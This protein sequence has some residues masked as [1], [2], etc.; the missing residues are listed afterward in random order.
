VRGGGSIIGIGQWFSSLMWVFGH[1]TVSCVAAK[2]PVSFGEWVPVGK[3]GKA[4]AGREVSGGRGTIS[5]VRV[6]WSYFHLLRKS[7]SCV[8]VLFSFSVMYWCINCLLVGIKPLFSTLTGHKLLSKLKSNYP[9]LSVS[10][11]LKGELELSSKVLK[12]RN[13]RKQILSY[14]NES[15]SI[16]SL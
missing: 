3:K 5:G 7:K 9:K 2:Q 13:N 1:S 16:R 6:F 8:L 12:R 4:K 14:S 10:L 15:K 11:L